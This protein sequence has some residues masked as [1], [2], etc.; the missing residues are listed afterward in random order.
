MTP[1]QQRL[2]EFI[3]FIAV[4]I[5]AAVWNRIQGDKRLDAIEAAIIERIEGKGV[6]P[7]LPTDQPPTVKPPV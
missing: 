3:V 6:G 7:E 2:A 4:T 5:G 1:E